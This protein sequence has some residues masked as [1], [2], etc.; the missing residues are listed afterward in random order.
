MR[1]TGESYVQRPT[2]AAR[3]KRCTSQGD[4]RCNDPGNTDLFEVIAPHGAL[5]EAARAAASLP[6]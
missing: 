5:G 1:E 3:A 2:L 6:A 4:P